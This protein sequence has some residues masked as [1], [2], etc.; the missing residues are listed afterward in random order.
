MFLFLSLVEKRKTENA[1]RKNSLRK[2]ALWKIDPRKFAPPPLGE[3][4]PEKAPLK[5][6]TDGKM[7][8]ENWPRETPALRELPPR[9]KATL[10]EI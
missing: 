5:F 3:L 8:P 7:L 6:T 2:I 1:S 9:N 4:P 10:Q